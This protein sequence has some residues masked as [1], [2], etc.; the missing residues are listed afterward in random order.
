[1]PVAWT[2]PQ[3]R[4]PIYGNTSLFWEVDG[5]KQKICYGAVRTMENDW[6]SAK[7]SEL[8]QFLTEHAPRL[9]MNI[10]SPSAVRETIDFL[11]ETNPDWPARLS[12]E[13]FA[14]VLKKQYP[15]LRFEWSPADGATEADYAE[16]EPATEK[17]IA[18]LRVLEAPVPEYLGL[19]EA[20]D[21]IEKW[22]NVASAGQKRRLDFYKLE[23][24]P[25]ITREEATALIDR[26]K[27]EHPES[28]QAY[29]DWK[30]RAGISP[31][32]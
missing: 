1:M 22:K 3:A 5:A 27:K 32:G 24:N 20:S 14:K 8:M 31:A 25:N 21:L 12:P 30:S 23:Y 2:T 9:H 19:R 6:K 4:L 28:E 26:F 16:D 11:C 13:D 29:Q 10:P 15:E 18:Y 7:E 17:Q